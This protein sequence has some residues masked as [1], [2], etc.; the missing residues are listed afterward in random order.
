MFH[1]MTVSLL[2]A[3][4]AILSFSWPAEV[5]AGGGQDAARA[6]ED[7]QNLSLS[8]TVAALEVRLREQQAQIDRLTAALAQ[9]QQLLDSQAKGAGDGTRSKPNDA[10]ANPSAESP[11]E[12][13]TQE[14]FQK[15]TTKVDKIGKD[16][17]TNTK[18]LS[19]FKFG[20]DFRLRFDGQWRAGNNVAGPLQNTRARYRLRLNIDREWNSHFKAHI[21]LAT[22]PF[23]NA[24]TNDTDMAGTVAKP[25]FSVAEA[26]AD[27]HPSKNFSLRGGRMEEVWADNMR[28]LWDDDVRFSGF[29]QIVTIPFGDGWKGFK[30]LEFRSGEYFLGNPN[31]VI[32]SPTSPFAAAGFT[33]GQKVRSTNLFDPGFILK[34]DLSKNWGHWI[35]ADFLLYRNPNTIQLASTNDGF[36]VVVNPVLG[37]SLSGPMT[38]TGN[39]TTTPGGAIYNAPRFD[40]ARVQYRITDKGL[41]LNGREM[42]LFVDLQVARNT[43]TDKHRDAAMVSANL[44]D[45][46]NAGDLRFLAQFGL[47]QA[48][49]MISQFTDDDFGTGSG[50]NIRVWAGRVDVGLTH[51]CQWQNIVFRQKEINGNIPAESFF[52]PLQ[53]GSKANMRWQSQVLFT[54]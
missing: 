39:A 31:I 49:S 14:E 2:V 48:N 42:P 29:Q 22:G 25:P 30:S 12:P 34:Q 38:G 5:F 15:F 9:Q 36:P 41:T 10:S 4:S 54:F 33:V 7:R 24:I 32:L 11:P 51:F 43:G 17:E 16:V 46:K 44:G 40:I 28:F 20:G 3:A 21:Q 35:T 23:N 45:V 8:D 13:V 6:Q 27:Y 52:V 26:W 18:D 1:R 19:G 47:K 53:A 50:V 37:L